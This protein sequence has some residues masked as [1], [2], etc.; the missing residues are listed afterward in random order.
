MAFGRLFERGSL[1]TK[2]TGACIGNPGPTAFV[3]DVDLASNVGLTSFYHGL[4]VL[5]I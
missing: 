2:T 4:C 3:M 5:Q 1:G